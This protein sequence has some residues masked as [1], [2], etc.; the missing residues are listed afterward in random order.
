[1]Q[2]YSIVYLGEIWVNTVAAPVR[3]GVAALIRRTMA[4][5]W[6]WSVLKLVENPG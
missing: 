3:Q 6:H 1:M 4:S 5:G 2:G